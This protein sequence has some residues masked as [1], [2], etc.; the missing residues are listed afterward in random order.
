VTTLEHPP[1]SADLTPPDFYL[2]PQLKSALK[3]RC[4][5]DANDM[6]KKCDRRAE[7]AFTKWLPGMFPTPQQ[8]LAERHSRT[9]RKCSLNDC[10]VLLA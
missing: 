8:W 3:G 4:F 6:M 2:F 7:K 10:T 9:G 5:C 1:H